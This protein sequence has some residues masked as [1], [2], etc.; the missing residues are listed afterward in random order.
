MVV[1]PSALLVWRPSIG[2]MLFAALEQSSA[3][4]R[5]PVCLV[6]WSSPSGG[7]KLIIL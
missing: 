6:A 3:W 2:P 7:A 5:V 4:A 1:V